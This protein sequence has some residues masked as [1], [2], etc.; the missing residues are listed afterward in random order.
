MVVSGVGCKAEWQV[1]PGEEA[2]ATAAHREV[3]VEQR[4]ASLEVLSEAAARVVA[5]LAAV[6]SARWQRS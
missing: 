5:R 6:V 2:A 3:A 4:A 1:A